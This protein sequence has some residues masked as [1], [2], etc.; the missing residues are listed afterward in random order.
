MPSVSSSEMIN[1]GHTDAHSSAILRLISEIKQFIETRVDLFQ[2][3][4][5][6]KLPLLRSAMLLGL[7][8]SAFLLVAYL[9]FAVAAV[10]L[11]GSAFPHNPYRWF[12]GFLIVGTL[13]VG[14]GAISAFLTTAG[15]TIKSL[16]PTRTFRILKGDK[17]WLVS[18][19][20]QHKP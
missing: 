4:V 1:A 9:F 11:I 13:T 2:T 18:E 8:G 15:F 5:K 12:F 6:Q 14:F 3:E 7:E 20:Q 19:I 17:D 10:V 16:L